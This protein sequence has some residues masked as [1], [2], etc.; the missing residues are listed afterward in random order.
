[1]RIGDT[2][3]ARHCRYHPDKVRLRSDQMD[4]SA[5][6]MAERVHGGPVSEA[7]AN[8]RIAHS[9]KR[10]EKLRPLALEAAEKRAQAMKEEAAAKAKEKAAKARSDRDG[11]GAAP[12]KRPKLVAPW[13][14]T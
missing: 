2:A 9:A 14:E 6:N 11:M 8:A 13:R 10:R 4:A 1:M 7:L 3:H 12:T 5:R